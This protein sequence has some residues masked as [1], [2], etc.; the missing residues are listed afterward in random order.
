M[1]MNNKEIYRERELDDYLTSYLSDYKAH[2]HTVSIK[3]NVELSSDQM[4]KTLFAYKHANWCKFTLGDYRE[5]HAVK[6][7]NFGENIC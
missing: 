1:E 6:I 7:L 5:T 3:W 4:P 2:R